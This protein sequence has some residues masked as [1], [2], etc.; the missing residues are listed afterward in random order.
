MKLNKSLI[1]FV[2]VLS[3]LFI[4]SDVFAATQ[5][6][7]LVGDTVRVRKGPGTN[8]EKWG[9]VSIGSTFDLIDSNIY[10]D[11]STS[12]SNKCESGW[13]K[14]QY[15]TDKVGYLCKSYVQ[16][17]DYIIIDEEAKTNCENE[18]KALKFPASY[19]D[20]LCNLKAL[21]PTWTFVPIQTGLDWKY[22]IDKESTCGLSLI[23]TSDKEYIDSSCNKGYGSWEAASKKAVSFYMDPRN[24]FTEKHI[25][26]FE[27]LK[28]STNLS[29][30]YINSSNSM[31]A[32]AAFFKYH[33]NLGN[34]MG[35]IIDSAGKETNVN[36]VFLSARM[37]QELGTKESLYN[38]YSGVY[39]G[40][41][42]MYKGYYNFYNMGVTDSCATTNGTSYCGLSYA[43]KK[44]WNSPLKAI[45]G[46]SQLLSNSYISV[47][48]YNTYLQKFNVVPTKISNLFLHQYMTNIK[49]PS[50]ESSSTYNTYKKLGLLNNSYEF[51]IPVYTNMDAIINNSGS[52]ATGEEEVEKE[53]IKL[54]V[55]TVVASAGYKISGDSLLGVSKGNDLE[56][57]KS[58]LEAISGKETIKFIDSKG[59]NYTGKIATGIKVKIT[60]SS[61]SK[62]LSIVVKGDTSG[63]GEI[64]ALDL[65]QVQKN[66]LK[67]YELKGA[68][69]LAADTS[70]DGEINALDLL[71]VQKNILGSYEIK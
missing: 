44:E 36:P 60:T 52:G 42:G 48:Q 7:T 10:P 34:D 69:K 51:H 38:L 70:G 54:S 3:S 2:I 18:L 25:F 31:L 19:W 40:Y 61:E 46:G 6:V 57:I 47:G 55:A 28:Y 43:Y 41:N 67:S 16:V 11:E 39:T 35:S 53:E 56:S 26:Q 8:Y 50:S 23:Q 14:I 58:N 9:N 65:L 13:Y 1:V 4:S 30:A 29:Q 68:Y 37:L 20:G 71:Q 24:F 17:S 33:K 62:E 15:A 22:V 32:N 12:E 49:A 45:T 63:D 64:N 21:H 59:N 27:Y 5:Y 66:I